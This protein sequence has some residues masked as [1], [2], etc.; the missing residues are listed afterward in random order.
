[1]CWPDLSIFQPCRCHE[2]D[3]NAFP[4]KN[5]RMIESRTLPV[6]LFAFAAEDSTIQVE[7]EARAIQSALADV[8]QQPKLC[9]I[10][11]PPFLKLL[12]LVDAFQKNRDRVAIFHYAG[13]ADGASLMLRTAQGLAVNHV[14]GANAAGMAKTV[15]GQSGLKLVFLNG[16]STENQV[17]HWIA[18]GVQCVIATTQRVN[19]EV[20]RN[21]ASRFYKGLATGASIKVAYD[22][23]VGEATAACGGKSRLVYAD[24]EGDPSLEAES[25]R[26][27]WFL[28]TAPGAE[29]VL[30]WNLPD[31]AGDPLALLPL[32]INGPLPEAPYPGLRR[33]TAA[34]A[35]VFFG[36]GHSIRRLYERVTSPTSAP[37]I[38]LHGQS[39]VGKSSILEAG[40]TPRLQMSYNGSI[41]CEVVTIRID[42]VRGLLDSLRL[43]YIEDACREDG[44]LCSGREAWCQ[45]EA[46]LQQPMVVI[47]DQL[48]EAFTHATGAVPTDWELF[49]AELRQIFNDR[50]HA[51]KG[52]LILSFRTEW[53][54]RI[55]SR[56]QGL[57]KSE[58]FLDCLDADGIHEA[59][60]GPTRRPELREYYPL[61]IA[62]GLSL[63]I[64]TELLMDQVSSV[65]PSLQII[66]QALWNEA[67]RHSRSPVFNEELYRRHRTTLGEFVW[68]QIQ[69]IATNRSV[70]QETRTAITAGLLVDFLE[71]HVTPELTTRHQTLQMLLD[72]DSSA[73]PPVAARYPGRNEI[74]KE[75]RQL[76][77]DHYLLIQP[78]NG[79][80]V[81]AALSSRLAHD[82]LAPHVRTAYE[83]SDAVGPRARRILEQRVRE[84]GHGVRDELDL[85]ALDSIERGQPGMREWTRQEDIIVKLARR[86]RVAHRFKIWAMVAGLLVA[87]YFVQQFANFRELELAMRTDVAGIENLFERAHNSPI[88]ATWIA[89]KHVGSKVPAEISQELQVQTLTSKP[90]DET[91]ATSLPFSSISGESPQQRLPARAAMVLIELNKATDECYLGV[92]NRLMQIRQPQSAELAELEIIVRM[93]RQYL[94]NTDESSKQRTMLAREFSRMIGEANA[95]PVATPLRTDDEYNIALTAFLLRIGHPEQIPINW[96]GPAHDQWQRTQ[97]IAQLHNWVSPEELLT[98]SVQANHLPLNSGN[99]SFTDHLRAMISMAIASSPEE[100]T[101]RVAE[102]LNLPAYREQRSQLAFQ[103]RSSSAALR[104]ATRTLVSRLH[105]ARP[106]LVE[107]VKDY[108]DEFRESAIRSIHGDLVFLRP[109]EKIDDCGWVRVEYSKPDRIKSAGLDFV[110]IP[111]IVIPSQPLCWMSSTEVPEEFFEQ[112][113]LLPNPEY[114][115]TNEA[116]I[117]RQTDFTEGLPKTKLSDKLA[118]QF[119]NWLS[120]TGNLSPL[121]SFGKPEQLGIRP[122]P[123]RGFR[124]PR[125]SEWNH[126]CRANSDSAA[127]HFGDFSKSGNYDFLGEYAWYLINSRSAGEAIPR[128]RPCATRLPNAW[129]MFDMIGN[130]AELRTSEKYG[131]G[132]GAPGSSFINGQSESIS[133]SP[134]RPMSQNLPPVSGNDMQLGQDSFAG[135]ERDCRFH[136]PVPIFGS[137]GGD[138]PLPYGKRGFRLVIET[139]GI[140]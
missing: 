134:M 120:T 36:R 137:D 130:V 15:Q 95:A 106:R 10:E 131:G 27:P 83:S 112:F 44:T 135:S 129:G 75:L 111:G 14:R 99:D 60:E 56:L 116:N 52:K 114:F 103:Y 78:D 68:N 45:K 28:Q 62:P 118:M 46:R 82:A 81:E 22:E 89:R 38:L 104:S 86:T 70:S 8:S 7:E 39:G 51:P 65:A 16:C 92:L 6:L 43:A 50:T 85:K 32:P 2:I 98:A 121:Y 109:A 21:F 108:D 58:V 123:D 49:H 37:V 20:A 64:A 18:A 69:S 132:V 139:I 3:S 57:W 138:E 88:M 48:E 30:D 110:K 126:A 93:T 119:C 53:F 4:V 55:N 102:L 136:E 5:E 11:I 31:A 71:C 17:S 34:D 76:C 26:W 97:L 101:S 73:I 133:A 100:Y 19:G 80:N 67:A 124:L 12:D 77:I 105:E 79:S 13:H 29:A 127:Y 91:V 128:P 59:I 125:Q 54:S 90:L 96:C 47:L 24:D 74:I 9:C 107:S 66:L 115:P 113:Y 63:R 23:A 40:L 25:G 35:P 1:M 61:T 94:E 140:N 84:W 117:S 42:P 87:G 33:F 122:L 72:G 41:P